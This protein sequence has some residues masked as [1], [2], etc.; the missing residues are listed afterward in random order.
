MLRGKGI[1]IWQVQECEGGDAQQ[2]VAQ[3][4]AAGLGHVLIKVTDGTSSFPG[5]AHEA[6]TAAAINALQTAGLDVWGWGF[7]YGDDPLGEADIA[8]QRVISLGLRG[9]VI[10]AE[11]QYR[12][13]PLGT[14]TQYMNRLRA[15]LPGA[16]LA[17]SS[18]RFPSVQLSLIHISEPTRP[19]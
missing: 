13:K 3:A 2:I 11:G 15:G 19:Y 1:F 16:P 6:V 12:D 14:A 4:Q 9:F 7:V 17:L 18:F 5:V 8:I 10:D